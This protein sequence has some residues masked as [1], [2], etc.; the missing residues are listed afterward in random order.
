MGRNKVAMMGLG[1][2]ASATGRSAALTRATTPKVT[3][4]GPACQTIFRKGGTFRR[5][6]SRSRHPLQKSCV[7][8]IGLVL[9]GPFCFELGEIL[10]RRGPAP[11]QWRRISS[12]FKAKGPKS[13]VK[14][15]RSG[16]LE[17]KLPASRKLP[18]PCASEQALDV[19]SSM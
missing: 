1:I 2:N 12:E 16:S 13:H 19:E 15:L 5:A 6:E 14:L 11:N 4:P 3:T 10:E 9:K 18:I 17:Q 7:P 8:T